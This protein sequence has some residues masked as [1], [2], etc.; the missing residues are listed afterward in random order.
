[1]CAAIEGVDEILI[2]GSSTSVSDFRHYAEKH[3]PAVAA[4]IVG[5]DVV[6]HPTE[7]QLVALAK[8]FFLKHDKMSDSA[9]LS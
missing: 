8:A 1:M 5:Y 6:D 7:N 4:Q 2:T 9:R 3:R